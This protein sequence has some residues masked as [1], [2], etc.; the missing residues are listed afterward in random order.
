MPGCLAAHPLP[1]NTYLPARKHRYTYLPPPAWLL[2]P[3]PSPPSPTAARGCEGHPAED[4]PLCG[5]RPVC[6]ADLPPGGPVDTP[7]CAAC[8]AAED[9]WGQFGMAGGSWG[10]RASAERRLTS[11][12]YVGTFACGA[13]FCDCPGCKSFHACLTW[14]TRPH[15]RPV[16]PPTSP[17][18]PHASALLPPLQV[19]FKPFL[20]EEEEP[21]EPQ[22]SYSYALA[23]ATARARGTMQGHEASGRGGGRIGGG[24][25]CRQAGR[26]R[27]LLTGSGLGAGKAEH[28]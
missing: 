17:R 14:W 12:T 20:P 27:S 4:C 18:A 26:W 11:T 6:R 25:R 1:P 22:A 23:E 24:Q 7:A 21:G 28:A 10:R 16:P 9:S 15:P 2:G 19:P 3:P 13:V 5:G 8:T